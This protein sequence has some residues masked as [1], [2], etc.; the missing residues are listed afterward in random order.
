MRILHVN[1][2][3][4]WRG[5]ERQTVLLMEGLQSLGVE[6]TLLARSGGTLVERARSEG[7]EVLQSGRLPPIGRLR[8]HDVVHAHEARAVGFAVVAKP[9]HRAPIVATRRVDNP[10]GSGWLTHLKYRRVDRLVAI[11][12]AVREAVLAW[13]P[14]LGP[15]QVIP[16]SVPAARDAAPARLAELRDRFQGRRV[17]GTVG[18]LVA[19]HKD[20]ATL[21]HAFAELASSR[22]DL[23]LVLIG[24]GNDRALLE[25]QVAEL[26]LRE[27]VIFEGFQPDP[28][29]YYAAMDV[30]ALTSRAEG[31]GTAIL[32]A[33]AYSVPVVATRAGGIPELIGDDE[34]GWLARAG[35]SSDVARCL[36]EA[37]DRPDEAR[38][39][40]SLALEHLS[41]KHSVEAM[42]AAYHALYSE[43]IGA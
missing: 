20:P 32:D 12:N 25:R 11:S 16:S 21:I 6:N 35:D 13:D 5:G 30:F 28:W 33:F 39:R 8:G 31:L 34:R 43:L 2:A 9:W 19:R 15:L 27:R 29:A 40:A 24:E 18:A 1:F 17:I 4:G 41:R 10:P 42:A 38:R 3:P 23:M 26:G 14:A 37:L 7:F 36:R 22:D